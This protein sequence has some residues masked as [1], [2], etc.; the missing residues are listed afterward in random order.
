MVIE[1]DEDKKID[2][3]YIEEGS[4]GIKE[5]EEAASRIP[6]SASDEW[7]KSTA[8]E[9]EEEFDIAKKNYELDTEQEQTLDESTKLDARETEVKVNNSLGRTMYES[10]SKFQDQLKWQMDRT[11]AI[12]DKV[13]AIQKQLMRINGKNY[14]NMK[15]H[16]IIKRMESQLNMLQKVLGNVDASVAKLNLRSGLKRRIDSKKP[17]SSKKLKKSTNKAY[18]LKK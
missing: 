15:E 7:I 4:E 11:K 5:P 12:E 6:S 8:Q 9:D 10:L 18:R 16:A 3:D 2:N 17:T 14:S 13:N 1:N